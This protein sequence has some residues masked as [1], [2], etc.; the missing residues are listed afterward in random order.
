MGGAVT[1]SAEERK[2]ATGRTAEAIENALSGDGL[3][4]RI[5]MHLTRLGDLAFVGVGGKLY[6]SYKLKIR[7]VAP[8]DMETVVL[9]QEASA[10]STVT[11]IL[12]ARALMERAESG[13]P[14]DNNPRIKPGSTE[15]GVV[16]ATKE[17]FERIKKP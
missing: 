8:I 5:R 11:Y 4:Y 12:D 1:M 9:G 3:P 7:E 17:M 15:E 13:F 2:S 10:L 6:N 16:T 14:G